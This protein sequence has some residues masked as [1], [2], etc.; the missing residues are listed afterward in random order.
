[1]LKGIPKLL[2]PELVRILMEMGHGDELVLA[3]ANYPGHSLNP[4]VL[5][6]DGIGIPELLDAILELLPLDHYAEQ[7]VAFMAVVAGDPTVPV[8]WST[9]ETIIAKHDAEATIKQEERF[10]F[11]NRSKQSYAVIVT[12][13]EALYGNVILKK[14]VIKS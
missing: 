11:Y 4:R 7:Q 13:E 12:G 1:M 9:Y 3:D 2:S 8:I 6:Y 5:R 10:D 14:G